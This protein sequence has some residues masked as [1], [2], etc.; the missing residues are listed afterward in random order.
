MA[1]LE[2]GVSDPL[3]EG[4]AFVQSHAIHAHFWR[5]RSCLAVATN[6]GSVTE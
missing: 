1:E 2:C 4:T 5:L 6:G 3:D